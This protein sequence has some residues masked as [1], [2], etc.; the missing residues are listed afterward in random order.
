MLPR[1][2]V[3]APLS[4]SVSSPPGFFAL[5][6]SEKERWERARRKQTGGRREKKRSERDG[7][8]DGCLASTHAPGT[9]PVRCCLWVVAVTVA[10]A[11]SH[12]SLSDVIACSGAAINRG[13]IYRRHDTDRS[14]HRG[15]GSYIRVYKGRTDGPT[16]F[17][18]RG[19]AC[20]ALARSDPTNSQWLEGHEGGP[21]GADTW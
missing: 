2:A 19:Q 13:L 14:T 1:F 15:H 12:P 7:D 20:R 5:A 11:A 21:W 6:L 10:V 17:L 16:L 8:G 9:V 4:L 3:F 18:G